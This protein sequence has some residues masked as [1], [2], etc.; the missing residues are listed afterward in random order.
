MSDADVS[1]LM[2]AN[3]VLQSVISVEEWDRDPCSS[4]LTRVID[5][6]ETTELP[7]NGHMGILPSKRW[8]DR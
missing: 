2:W 8:L 7:E 1:G 3:D 5:V 6:S 4:K